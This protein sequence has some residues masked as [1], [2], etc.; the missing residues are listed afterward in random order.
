MDVEMRDEPVTPPPLTREEEFA[1][2]AALFV[3]RS[4]PQLKRAIEQARPRAEAAGREAARLVRENEDEIRAA[5]L[6]LA[7]ARLGP[8]G[9]VAGALANGTAA[10]SNADGTPA[11]PA[12]V[13]PKPVVSC[14]NCGTENPSAA[15]F[16]NE[17][18][19]RLAPAPGPA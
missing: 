9:M 19:A 3:K 16:C 12:L 18:G 1:R 8:L 13:A 10:P 7:Q 6:K 5:A 4:K 14:A 15:N 17:C 11:N 2:K